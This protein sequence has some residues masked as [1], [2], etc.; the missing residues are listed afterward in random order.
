MPVMKREF[1]EWEIW[2]DCRCGVWNG[3]RNLAQIARELM[4]DG[5]T[6]GTTDWDA[7][8]RSFVRYFG[9]PMA[10]GGDRAKRD[11]E[12]IGE[13]VYEFQS[14]VAAAADKERVSA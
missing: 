4:Q 7:V 9:T 11:W 5:P 1:S 2:A 12:I 6:F 13:I 14:L 8:G 10:L 3:Y